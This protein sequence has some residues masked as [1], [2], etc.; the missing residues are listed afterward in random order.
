MRRILM[1]TAATLLAAAPVSASAQTPGGDPNSATPFGYPIGDERTFVHGMLSEFEGRFGADQSFRYEGEGWV[2]GDFNRLRFRSEGTVTG[3]RLEDG[4]QE[5]LYARPISTYFDLQAGARYDADS[6][7]GR[8]WA[9]FGVEGLA[10]YMFRVAATAYASSGGHYALKLSVFNEV[11]FTQ[12][13][14]LEPQA[15]LNIYTK[16][17]L[18]RRIGSGV[19][20]LDS[21]L[22]LRYEITRKFA[23]YVGVVYERRFARTGDLARADGGRGD[24][25]RFAVGARSW[26]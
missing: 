25:V 15:E 16:D 17:D 24:D 23:P 12:R 26:F 22:R 21:G 5:L 7:R 19:S 1:A 14:I 4:Q 9:A 13:L 18:G 11:R 6:L 3:G 2:G 10:P 20:D 8:G